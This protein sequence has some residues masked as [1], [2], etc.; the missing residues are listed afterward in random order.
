MLRYNRRLQG[1][2]LH[3]AGKAIGVTRAAFAYYELN[4]GRP[5]LHTARRI[6][7]KFNVDWRLWYPEYNDAKVFPEYNAAKD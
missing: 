5:R 2:T 4:R 7:E 6:S 1:L 3:E